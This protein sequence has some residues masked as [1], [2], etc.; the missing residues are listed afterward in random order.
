M[1]APS[2]L[3]GGACP[4]RVDC[5]LGMVGSPLRKFEVGTDVRFENAA[6]LGLPISCEKNPDVF[7]VV[8]A[9]PDKVDDMVVE[10]CADAGRASTRRARSPNDVAQMR[11]IHLPCL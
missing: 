11:T 3:L 1:T 10:N 9:P 7:V 8:A 6:K 5:T 2:E 4:S